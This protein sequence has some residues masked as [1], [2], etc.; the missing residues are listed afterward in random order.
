VDLSN[1]ITPVEGGK[2]S[3]GRKGFI[4]FSLEKR[5]DKRSLTKKWAEEISEEDYATIPNGKGE[6]TN[7]ETP[8]SNFDGGERVLLADES[9]LAAT[10]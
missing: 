4:G 2:G 8:S 5:K 6:R 10:P 9:L 3:I 1:I 7:D